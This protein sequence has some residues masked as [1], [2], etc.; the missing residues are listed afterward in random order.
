M[1]PLDA[2]DA[3]DTI[4]TGC[5]SVDILIGQLVATHN[6][7]WSR[8]NFWNYNS[9]PGQNVDISGCTNRSSS[10]HDLYK[11]TL[12][13][14]LVVFEICQFFEVR[15]QCDADLRPFVAVL[16]HLFVYCRC[17][18]STLFAGQILLVVYSNNHLASFA[19]L[20]VSINTK[21]TLMKI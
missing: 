3:S 14:V 18:S 11:M 1:P 7:T 9:V 12:P 5:G 2:A 16:G 10:L 4:D 8:Y 6:V 21:N 17:L 15:Y 19:I 13:V 20:P